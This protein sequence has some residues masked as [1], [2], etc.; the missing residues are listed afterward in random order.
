MKKKVGEHGGARLRQ[1]GRQLVHGKGPFHVATP[2]PQPQ[3][4]SPKAGLTQTLNP[5]PNNQ[6]PKPQSLSPKAQVQCDAGFAP[7]AAV[8][9]TCQANL[10]PTP[11]TLH[12]APYTLHP[13]PYT[14][15]PTSQ[16]LNPKPQT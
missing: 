12:P 16:T 14:L 7:E 10:H 4:S 3:T 5:D 1:L 15:H 8:T 9:A 11:Y 13:S 6:N 2:T